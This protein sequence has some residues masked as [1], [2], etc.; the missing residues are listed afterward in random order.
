MSKELNVN[1]LLAELETY[2]WRD[3]KAKILNKFGYR[4][5]LDSYD[6]E[7]RIKLY[8]EQKWVTLMKHCYINEEVDE[9]M[10]QGNTFDEIVRAIKE[11]I[12]E[13]LAEEEEK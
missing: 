12:A 9:L 10:L 7:E 3:K 13:K 6:K 4:L 2:R 8:E 5:H 11:H 1:E